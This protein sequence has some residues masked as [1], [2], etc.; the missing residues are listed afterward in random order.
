MDES[1]NW[2]NSME[3][4]VM[5][6]GGLAF[7]VALTAGTIFTPLMCRLSR[8]W[9]AVDK[10]DGFLKWHLQTTSTLGGIPLFLSMLTAVIVLIVLGFNFP[11]MQLK[12]SD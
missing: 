4:N 8:R 10:P 5:F 6:A 1:Y 11:D 7:L 2:M 12:W 9:G 3:K